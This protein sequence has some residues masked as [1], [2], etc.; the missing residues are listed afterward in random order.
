MSRI[1]TNISSLVAQKTLARTQEQLQTALT[2]LSTGLRINSGKDDPA[3]LIA[4][5]AL[6][7]T[8]VSTQQAIT[9][10]QRADQM[11]STADSALGQISSL[12][13]DVRSL[14]TEAT[15]NA[16]MSPDQIA[17]NQLQI[18]SSLEAINRIAQTTQFQ[19]KRLLDGTLDFVT[20]GVDT[21]KIGNLAIDQANFGTQSQVNVN[22]QVS[23][24]AKQAALNYKGQTLGSAA[25]VE[26][27]GVNGAQTFQFGAGSTVSQIAAAVNASSDATGVQAVLTNRVAT[28]AA[29]GKISVQQV[30]G[31][32]G[33]VVTADAAGQYA[34]NF[35][36]KYVKDTTLATGQATATLSAGNPSV[37]QVN[38]AADAAAAA[39]SA[40]SI[41]VGTGAGAGNGTIDIA[42][43]N[44]GTAFNGVTFDLTVQGGAESATYNYTTKTLSVVANAGRTATQVA[45]L[46]TDKYG[47]LFTVTVGGGTKVTQAADDQTGT[48]AT[49]GAGVDG[50]TVT[51]TLVNIVNAINA[52]GAG[53]PG[54][55][56]TASK[57]HAADANAT[58]LD[59]ITNSG[60]IGDINAASG[61]DQPNNRVQL[62]A[63]DAGM[64]VP[65]NFVAGGPNQSFNITY[66]N[67]TRTNGKSTAYLQGTG[68]SIVKLVSNNQGTAYDGIQIVVQDDATDQGVIYDKAAKTIT[69]NTAV[70][71]ATATSIASQISGA[72]GTDFTATVVNDAGAGSFSDG[73]SATTADGALYDAVN[74]N[75]ATDANGIVTTTANEVVNAMNADTNLQALGIHVSNVTSSDGSGAAATGSV[76]L[77][78]IGVTA[79]N[80]QAA[81]TTAA[82]GG[83]TAQ[84]TVT[85]ANAGAAYQNVKVAFATD[86]SSVTAGNEYA[87]YDSTQKILTFHI[88]VAS[89]AADVANSFT[90]GSGTDASVKALFG[91]AA[92]NGGAGTVTTDDVGWLRNGVTYSGTTQG[93]IGSQGNFDAG[94]VV[95]TSGVTFQSTDYGATQFV[96]VNAVSG[97]FTVYNANDPDEAAAQ[98]S[99]GTNAAVKLNGVDA[100]ADGLNISLN[101]A[102]LG[103]RFKLGTTLAAG[104]S[105]DFSIVS[106]GALF[107]LGADVVS[108]QQARLGI[109]SVSTTQLS[110]SYGRLRDLASGGAAS[111]A[112]SPAT[113][114][115]ILND[116]ASKVNY[117]RGRLGAFQKTTLQTNIASLQDA[118]TNLTAADSS[119][120]DADF[121]AESANLTRAQVL[122]QAGTQVLSIANQS[123]QN[124]L[125][126]LRNA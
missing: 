19:G 105:L 58:V 76:T 32:E 82:A 109:A 100:V 20:Q 54:N 26:I 51:A 27:A 104:S 103:M 77:S 64:N 8:I 68:G 14:V 15:N 59:T 87:T 63:T 111:L 38:V 52:N 107:Q 73:D 29:D 74:V 22:V 86:D 47:S 24:Q 99:Y 1:N 56:V 40:G 101:T 106:G 5:S 9:N 81:G 120:T 37:I 83:N 123:P 75:L 55:F 98:R 60:F 6:R 84:I 124:V 12:L 35:T 96:N 72:L 31:T 49:D 112:N 85:A 21:A 121:A 28:A 43:K 45:T 25:T 110:G 62:T 50:G 10:S 30:G 117:L 53:Q 89:T 7:T 16:A 94:Q 116:A 114:A 78:Q 91:V 23:N 122:V 70:A 33:L 79:T 67:N 108:N 42:A 118:V 80:A 46:I 41:T 125:A 90:T 36:I 2:R 13:N 69:V 126:L 18:D 4:H 65:V 102:G 97:T 44:N 92:E 93:G 119:I 3:G 61:T 39:G 95:G 66:Q 88:D 48:A 113:A 11:I 17:A 34:G 71:T 57:L 115:K